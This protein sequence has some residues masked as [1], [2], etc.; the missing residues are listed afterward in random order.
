MTASRFKRF[1]FFCAGVLATLC[2]VPAFAAL[3][4]QVDR[5]PVA[6]NETFTL[7]LQTSDSVSG[8]PD[9]GPLKRDFDVLGQNK[10]SSVQIVNGQ[11]SRSIRW[12]VSLTAKHGGQLQIPPITVDGQTSAPINVNVGQASQGQ[13]AQQSSDLF[14]EFS[15][16]PQTV[17]V[18]QQVVVTVRLFYAVNIGSGSLSEPT[19]PNMDAMAER[20][21]AD[22]KYQ[23]ERH[24][25]SYSVTERRYALF[26]QKNGQFASDPLIFDGEI[27][28]QNRNNGFL[29]FNPFGQTSR[30]MRMRSNVVTL[31][32]KPIPANYSGD[33]WLP[34]GKLQLTEKWSADPATFTVGEPITRTIE[35][36]ANGLTAAQLPSVADGKA[37]D[38]F[39]LYP[40]Q[41][42]LTD[43]KNDSGIVGKRV[44]K[45]AYIPTR[46]GSVTLPPVEVKWW[47][48]AAGKEQVATLPA[49]SFSVL[50]GK[51]PA[52]GATPSTLPAPDA[53]APTAAI[54]TA[55][56]API[57][58][59]TNVSV[60]WWPWLSLTLACGWGA[61]LF[62]WWRS[63]RQIEKPA[64]VDPLDD[65]LK[66]V[67]R[68][69]KTRCTGNDAVASKA[70]LLRWARLQWPQ[71]P[72]VS[73]T[74][75]ARRSKPELAEALTQLDRALYANGEIVW[76]GAEL[77]QL[78]SDRIAENSSTKPDQSEALK[79]LYPA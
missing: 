49:R 62:L 21:G 58:T 35:L 20:L 26:P 74:A 71:D 79:P 72:P 60:G 4:A 1:L 33:P 45:I 52:A 40:D 9:L 25:Q 65:S 7:I 44:Q 15:A 19:F 37:V 6:L 70:L 69:L 11:I 56:T 28:E 61:T 67:I 2:C 5:N 54:D 18:Q 31:T 13:A 76:H 17:Y 36:S 34:A 23:T 50:P 66:T 63:R 12:Q 51:Q 30:H 10:S 46:P 39:K 68:Q 14:L 41:A 27:V 8:D 78:I 3:Q 57:Q 53:A 47:D 64:S 29:P 55:V 24:G 16:E 48:A 42:Q 38:G 32:V 59:P 77:A 22:R 43:D 73:L 75:I